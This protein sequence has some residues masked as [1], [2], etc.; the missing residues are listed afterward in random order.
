MEQSL[1]II[2]WRYKKNFTFLNN[3]SGSLD[4]FI[5]VM[6]ILLMELGKEA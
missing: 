2:M 6:G 1:L 3:V 5:E 4:I